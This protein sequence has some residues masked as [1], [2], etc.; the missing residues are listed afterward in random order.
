MIARY[1]ALVELGLSGAGF[2]GAAVSWL[3]ARSTVAVAPVL[4]GQP[5]ITSVVYHAQPLA[6]TLLLM[7]IAGV[8]AVV[9]VAR[10]RRSK[11]S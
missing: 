1:R 4:D 8:V 2:G 7:T 9:G 6:L 3:H 11:G 10:L 5:V